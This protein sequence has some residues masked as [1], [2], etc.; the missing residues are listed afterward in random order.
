MNTTYKVAVIGGTG[1]SGTYLVRQLLSGNIPFRILL[2]DPNKFSI[3][4]PL[5]E[6]VKGDAR[7]GDAVRSL[8]SGCEAVISTLGQPKGERSIFSDSTRNII[9]A[10]D[11]FG[12][13]RYILTTGLNV[14]TEFDHK[15][16]KSKMATEWMKTNYPE[17]TFDKQE[18][19]KLLVQ[20]SVE[21]TLVRLPLIE[22]TDSGS[23]IKVSLDDCPGDKI[24]AADLAGFL[25]QQLTEGAF[26]RKA[27][28]IASA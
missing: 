19:Y 14:D 10:M 15:G 16:P 20:S 1:K 21:W 22:L 17:T 8:I 2:R 24:S 28:F 25:I 11:E 23:E 5:I 9:Q 27:P 4:S 13:K 7:D 26:I 3:H 18:E 12:V 6:V